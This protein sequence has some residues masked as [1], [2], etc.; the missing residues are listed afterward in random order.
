MTTNAEPDRD[1]F[2]A[3]SESRTGS[4]GPAPAPP[5]RKCR[6]RRWWIRF[7]LGILV[8]LIILVALAPYLASTATGSRLI[9]SLVNDQIQGRVGVEELSLSWRGPTKLSG[10][11]VVDPA[12]REVLTVDQAAWPGGVWTA[13][14]S[15]EQLGN[16]SVDSPRAVLHIDEH[17]Q[18]SLVQAFSLRKQAVSAE[19]VVLPPLTG[20]VSL[21]KGSIRMVLSDGR[22]YDVPQLDAKCD[23]DALRD[24]KGTV[25]VTLADAS[26]VAVD[27]AIRQFTTSGRPDLSRASGQ[28]NVTTS[29]EVDIASLTQFVLNQV[30]AA[31]KGN[32]DARLTFQ[33]GETLLVVKSRVTGVQIA[34]AGTAEVNPTDLAIEGQTRLTSKTMSA[35]VSLTGQAGSAQVRMAYSPSGQ[36]VQ[37]SPQQLLS[38]VVTGNEIAMPDFSIDARSDVDLATLAQAVP[39]LLHIRPGVRITSGRLGI[40]NLSIRGG[41]QPVLNGS[42]RLAE[43]TAVD[44]GRTSRWE[45]IAAEF[46]VSLEADQGLKIHRAKVESGFARVVARGT[47][48][49]FQAELRADLARLS[50]QL[51][52]VVDIGMKA[53]AGLITG[54]LA[55]KRA[56]DDRIDVTCDLVASDLRHQTE[57]G[58]MDVAKAALRQAGYLSLAGGKVTKFA[59]SSFAADIDGHVVASGSG[60]FDVEYGTYSVETN[61]ESLD[62]AYLGSK[63]AGY[64]VKDLDRYAGTAVFRTKIDRALAGGPVVSGGQATFRNSTVDGEP[65]AKQDV[66]L[67]WSNARWSPA[68]GTLSIETAE[69]N[70]DVAQATA[71]QVH[72][73]VRE[74]VALDGQV[75]ATADIARCLAAAGRIGQWKAPPQIAGRLVLAG[76]CASAAGTITASGNCGIDSLEIGTGKQA[77][78]ENR[79]ELAYDAVVNTQEQSITLKRSQL[80]SQ[81]LSAKMAGTIDRYST[82]CLLSLSG[83]Y[84]G[85]WDSITALIHELAPTT[86]DVLSFAGTTAGAFTVTGPAHQPEIRPVYRGVATGLDVGWTSVTA[87]GVTL[88]KAQL[89]PA[90]RDGE[91]TIPVTAITATVGQVRLGGVI[92]LRT[93]DPMFRL[94]GRVLVVEGAQITPEIGKHVLSRINPI[95]AFMTRAEGTV[96][97]ATQ[98]VLIPLSEQITKSG[99]A[100]GRLD[101]KDFKVQ[102]G[103]PMALLLELGALSKQ[104]MLT[105]TM[106]GAD[107]ALRDGRISYDNFTMVFPENFDLRFSGS[108][109]LDETVDLIVSVPIR[110]GLLEKFGVRGPVMEYARLLEG[111]RVAVPISG[112]RLLPKVDLARVDIKPLVERAT[113]SA[114]AGQAAGLIDALRKSKQDSAGKGPTD[115]SPST[116]PPGKPLEDATKRLL[117]GLLKDR[118]KD[119]R[120]APKKR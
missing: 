47:A 103:G 28:V 51:G 24:L 94:P 112:N 80:S 17:N 76:T 81:L 36:S 61:V 16:I 59:A 96:S 8:L 50:Q 105:V 82:E 6:R 30:S 55:V 115:R 56:G 65:L 15:R 5:Q 20:R 71:R 68:L 21:N 46:D 52:Q 42:I 74:G 91:L 99:S 14:R 85:S 27:A 117:D 23:V 48:S 86:R 101:M 72:W 104:N 73:K 111:A 38:A 88:G 67:G 35:E 100:K 26:T 107:F 18:I 4:Q 53:P 114:A 98:D 58:Q 79:A 113:R 110:A 34:R 31:G 22:T 92:D 64:G 11:T 78:R 29:G 45:P 89:S 57:K 60:W 90:L 10:L 63:A 37:T 77:V 109:G 106:D 102:F 40:E 93:P 39:A 49:E 54:T 66:V 84:E 19:P 120:A 62:L 9:L 33:P 7:P 69:L 70:S 116:Q 97:L 32:L 87:Y 95:F 13:L 75:E 108:V 44:S 2:E 1:A 118:E 83:S 43:L 12:G 25:Q 3:S 41:A 119:R